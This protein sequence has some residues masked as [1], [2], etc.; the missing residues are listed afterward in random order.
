MQF[1]LR[2]QLPYQLKLV[3]RTLVFKAV[4]GAGRGCSL[5]RPLSPGGPRSGP[6]R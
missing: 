3:G 5:P 2:L 1:L 4:H 6:E